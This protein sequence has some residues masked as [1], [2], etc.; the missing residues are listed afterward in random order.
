MTDNYVSSMSLNYHGRLDKRNVR[1]MVKNGKSV[2]PHKASG[3]M[4]KKP[5]HTLTENGN[6][7][8]YYTTYA[9]IAAYA[10]HY[11]INRRKIHRYGS[12]YY[13]KAN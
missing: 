10:D 12:M 1:A 4:G 2:N 6:T 9:D 11:G 7:Y 8:V 13:C 5:E 3:F